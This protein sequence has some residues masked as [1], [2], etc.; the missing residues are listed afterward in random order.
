MLWA[1]GNGCTGGCLAITALVLA[2][3]QAITET[4]ASFNNSY[5]WNTN[6]GNCDVQAVWT[7]ELGHALGIAVLR[8]LL[9]EAGEISLDLD[10]ATLM[11][12]VR[13]AGPVACPGAALYSRW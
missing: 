12:G 10:L 11:N 1:N 9:P 3:G 7:H 13:G 4:D 2:S 8:F 5:A 6:G